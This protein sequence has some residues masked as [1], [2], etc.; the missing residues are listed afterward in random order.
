M[1]P[2][3]IKTLDEFL[4]KKTGV[5]ESYTTHLQLSQK[6]FNCV[7]QPGL[8]QI[9]TCFYEATNPSNEFQI[10]NFEAQSRIASMSCQEIRKRFVEVCGAMS[11]LSATFKFPSKECKLT[12]FELLQCAFPVHEFPHLSIHSA[13]A[14]Q[15]F[16]P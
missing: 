9:S 5:K 2:V 8:R 11:P 16:L 14:S 6:A 1:N 13:R 15:E 7:S 4:E 10:G 12:E 3:T